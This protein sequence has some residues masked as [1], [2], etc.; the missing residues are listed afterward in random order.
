MQQ[1]F[2]IFSCLSQSTFPNCAN[3]PAR[4]QKALPCL[5]VVCLVTGNFVAPEFFT[6]FG[7][8]EDRAVMPVPKA[9]MNENHCPVTRQDDIRLAGQFADMQAKTE[10]LAV[11][12]TAHQF[13]GLRVVAA[14]AGH[15]PAAGCRIDNVGHQA[16]SGSVIWPLPA[17]LAICTCGIMMR[18]TSRMTGMT[19]LLPNWR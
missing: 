6:G 10:S 12:E 5:G 18:A 7:H 2:C 3:S 1:C 8:P 14:Y 4:E 15:H 17:L 19:T 13:F 11:Q 16:D 9:A